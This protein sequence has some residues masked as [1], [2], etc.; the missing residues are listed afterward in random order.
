[1][2]PYSSR[3]LFRQMC[4]TQTMSVNYYSIQTV[5]LP[6]Q[7]EWNRAVASAEK[8]VG[9]PTS[10]LNLQSLM[11]N[12]DVTGMTDHMRKLMGSDHPV[13]K[14]MK[15][16]VIH[17]GQNNVQVRGLM[18]LLMSKALNS[19]CTTQFLEA[20]D[21]ETNT[22]V[23]IS[24]RKLAEIVEMISAAY[25]IH[26]SVLN[27]PYELPNETEDIKEDLQQLE[28]G[29][30]IAILGGDYL[31]ANACVSLANLRN[32]YIVEMVSIAISE[33]T[34]SEFH[35][36]R[37]VQGRLIPDQ[38]SIDC[39][40]WINRNKMAN[41]SLLA[42]GFKGIGMLAQLP[43]D[44]TEK[45]ERI[46]RN[47]ALSLQAF[48]ELQPFIE[49]NN[50]D[51]DL[52][53]GSA[54][55]LFHL[56][57]D[58]DLLEYIATCEGDIDNLDLKKIYSTVTKDGSGIQITKDLCKTHAAEVLKDMHDIPDGDAKNALIRIVNYLLNK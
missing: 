53:L 46:G 7:H 24:Q 45:S 56:Q 32:S 50:F 35:G 9:F 2:L 40:W 37:D 4:K 49:E 28:Y 25:S 48:I 12:D 57:N 13:L 39:K 55:V 22:G 31:L 3:V 18:M 42:S 44:V 10:L 38:D 1:M 54:P 6:K 58:P 36:K 33:F 5:K 34:Q 52:S 21:Y 23:L 16:L 8:M 17:G 30:K 11:M 20:N 51:S 29:N 27:L 26:K 15:R 14:S 43:D 47:L 41:G 19:S